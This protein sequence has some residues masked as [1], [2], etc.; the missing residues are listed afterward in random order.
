MKKADNYNNSD[1]SNISSLT[2]IV[3]SIGAILGAAI[4][5]VISRLNQVKSSLRQ[6]Q[7][8]S[9]P[10]PEGGSGISE[11]ITYE[12][13]SPS[14]LQPGT[15]TSSQIATLQAESISTDQKKTILDKQTIDITASSASSTA[16]PYSGK[17][18]KT[19]KPGVM[20]S[21]PSQATASKRWSA[22]TRYIM[23]VFLFLAMIVVLWIGRSAIPIVVA[24]ALLALF[25]D[26]LV[27]FFIRKFKMKKG[28][29]VALTY[30]LVISLLV[31][32]PILA[33]PSLVNA[34]NFIMRIDTQLLFKRLSEVIQSISTAI[35]T[36]PTLRAYIQP[37][38]DSLST[39]INAWATATQAGTPTFNLSVEELASRFGQALGS[40]SKILGP[41][42]SFL[43][44]L[45]LTLL[46]SLQMTLTADGMKSW[47]ADL[48]PTGYGPELAMMMQKIRRTWVGFLRGQM[49]LMLLIGV[50]TWLGATILGLP[51]ALLLGVIA[52]VMELIPSIG[53]TLAAVPAVL[54][55]LFVGSTYLP[56]SNLVFALIVIGF[57]VLVQ[58][59]ENQLIV[60]KLMGDAV[61]LPPLVVL[62]G[63]IAGAGAFGILGALLATPVIATGN[64]VFRYV[65]RKI[66]EDQPEPPPVEEKPGFMDNVKGFLSRM[67]KLFAKSKQSTG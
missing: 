60:P 23:G 30:L 61:D 55:A 46:I 27:G 6:S 56:V 22:P 49:S 35:Q 7:L 53:P 48:I 14:T 54:L 45:F 8:P 62:I 12:T 63:T 39:K 29:A 50:V 59:L 38:L 15:V 64:L 51:Q 31:L 52:G 44:S 33:I 28:L 65:Y 1:G 40:L 16:I 10:D 57:Y 47:Y 19:D 5:L 26:P 43:A 36:N 18:S 20:A 2:L 41:T 42:I 17:S 66:V 11:T 58:L 37:V 9:P 4:S 25:V 3:F 67:P 32:I 13:V 24:A 34:V 21:K